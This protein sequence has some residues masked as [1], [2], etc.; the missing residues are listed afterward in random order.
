MKIWMTR[1]AWK[2]SKKYV[3]EKLSFG[4]Y[5]AALNALLREESGTRDGGMPV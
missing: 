1:A 5:R 3:K 2:N 4:C